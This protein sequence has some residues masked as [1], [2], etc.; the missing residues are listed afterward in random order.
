MS[1]LHV[2]YIGNFQHPWCTE[3]HITRELEGLGHR[4][5]RLQEPPG[6]RG[7]ERFVDHVVDYC[8]SSN[9]DLLMFTRTWG[10]PKTA[11]KA[12]R[13][14]ERAGTVTASYHLD[15]YV[16]L[17]RQRG[18]RTD[19]FWTTQ[20][21]F[22][23]DGDPRSLAWFERAGINHHWMPPG[24]VSDECVRGQKRAEFEYDVVFVG[25]YA[26]HH[27]WPW[28]P[29]LIDHLAERYGDRFRRF[30]GGMP[31]APTRGQDLNDVYASARV[32]V[33]DSLCMPGHVNYWSDRPYE[34]VG[35]GG[36]LVMP[37]VPGL[38][39]HFD[40][41]KHLLFYELG[42][43]DSVDELVD[44]YLDQPTARSVISELGQAHVRAHH[45]YKHR[46]ASALRTMGLT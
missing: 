15:L 26:Y 14:I 5:T 11:T 34:T 44:A 10:L 24:V 33:G 8:T 46:L 29:Q 17:H 2:A 4:V 42:S 32:V 22:T 21:V 18:V 13:T 36:F 3:V 19:P 27:E 38:D 30:G 25:S 7:A 39:A 6:G 40:D 1:G 37:R 43:L 31:D 12:W 20:H 9:V 35:R 23:P 41:G 28:R 45:T 16:G